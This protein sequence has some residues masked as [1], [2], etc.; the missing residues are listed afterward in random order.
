M[1]ALKDIDEKVLKKLCM[2]RGEAGGPFDAMNGCE[3]ARQH[4]GEP[5]ACGV[6]MGC[7]RSVDARARNKSASQV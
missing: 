5:F 1:S 2:D 6:E 3:Y 4:E 7:A